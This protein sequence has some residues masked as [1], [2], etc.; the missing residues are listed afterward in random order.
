VYVGQNNEGLYGESLLKKINASHCRNRIKIT[1]WADADMFKAYLEIAD[2]AVQLRSLSRGETS[3]AVLDCL[4]YGIATIVNANGSMSDI[5]DASIFKLPDSF[6]DAALSEALNTL[7]NDANTREQVGAE[8]TR[9]IH[10]NHAPR[11]C[12]ALYRDAIEA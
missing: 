12:A 6:E 7:R 3:A 9:L 8:A 11:A 2:A 1:G 4:N 5:P 10:T